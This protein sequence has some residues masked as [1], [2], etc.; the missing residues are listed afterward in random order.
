MPI[1]PSND[2]L[3][4]PDTRDITLAGQAANHQ[5]ARGVFADYLARKADNTLRRQA[6]DLARFATFLNDVGEQAGLLAGY[7]AR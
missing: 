6:A 5:A 7:P 2:A 3:M 1:T 4:P